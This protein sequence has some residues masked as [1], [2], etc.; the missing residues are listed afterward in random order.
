M[1]QGT[2]LPHKLVAAAL[3]DCSGWAR[4]TSGCTWWKQASRGAPRALR[5]GRM[6]GLTVLCPGLMQ[7]T[8]S[9]VP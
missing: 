3:R 5:L 8:S 7:G 4:A 1:G 2:L 6:L 9:V